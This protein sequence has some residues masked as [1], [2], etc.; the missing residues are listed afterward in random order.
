[1][2]R[3]TMLQHAVSAR[4]P[5]A[6]MRA[7]EAMR[8][9]GLGTHV[10]NPAA[11]SALASPGEVEAVFLMPRVTILAFGLFMLLLAVLASI[12]VSCKIK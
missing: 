5:V 9:L 10:A 1:M 6:A 2:A 8:Q 12:S 7:S 4:V 3:V 11:I